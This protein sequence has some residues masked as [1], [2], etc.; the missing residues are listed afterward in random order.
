MEEH[1]IFI[2]ILIIILLFFL[3]ADKNI[4][5]DSLDHNTIPL[6]LVL[7]IFYFCINNISLGILLISI[8][9]L[10]LST[11]DMKKII[12]E[13]MTHYIDNGSMKEGIEQFGLMFVN[14]KEML[15]K[16]KEYAD[17]KKQTEADKRVKEEENIR[18]EKEK[19]A[20]K[21]KNL[22]YKNDEYER[23]SYGN[24]K[25][26]VDQFNNVDRIDPN[27]I[28]KEIPV[29]LPIKKKSKDLDSLMN[30]LDNDVH[31]L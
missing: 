24:F 14:K 11:T 26:E 25:K 29:G 4:T 12:T 3:S 17:K 15:Q 30:K 18:L 22:L 5:S 19:K 9:F 20:E 28:K 2:I 7:I 23:I 27:K 10:V 8:I 31:K 16:A 6:L 1:N 21:S 13:R